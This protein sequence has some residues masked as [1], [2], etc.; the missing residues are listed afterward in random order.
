MQSLQAL[1]DA[2]DVAALLRGV[3]GLCA[4][5]E[6]DDLA[7]LAR[8]CRDAVELGK[9]LWPVATHIDYRLALEGPA[10]HAA[11]VLRPGAGRFALGPL[12]EV[13]ASTHDWASLQPHLSDPVSASAVAQERVLR[14]EDLRGR[15]EPEMSELPLCGAGWEPRY[16]LPV[17]RDRSAQFPQPEVARRALPQPAALSEGSLL[18]PDL[19]AQ[20]LQDVVE[21]W[22][23][24]SSGVV[25]A[26]AVEGDAPA[27]VAQL[28]P[29]ASLLPI[30]AADAISWLQW[31]GASGGAHGHR[32][33]GAAGRFAAWW[34]AAALTGLEWP[35]DRNGLQALSDALGAQLDELEW[36]RWGPPSAEVGWALR[37]AVHDPRDG[38]AWAV[39]ALDQVDDATVDPNGLQPGENSD[40]R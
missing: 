13:A 19:G 26:I 34:A 35:S 27:A 17:Y 24:Q 3:D 23:S 5:R 32:R 20:A 22:V 16:E 11:A 36:V 7:D 8:R 37:L 6:W 12:T 9:Q 30:S 21:A 28:A 4:T 38:L 33:G 10:S 15:G 25:R 40:L 1:V 39:E 29:Q 2:A 31:T 14:G 18:S